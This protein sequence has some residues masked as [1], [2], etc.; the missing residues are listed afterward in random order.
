MIEHLARYLHYLCFAIRLHEIRD[1]QISLPNHYQ[2]IT[3]A[4]FLLAVPGRLIY[5]HF[6]VLSHPLS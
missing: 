2:T 3:K 6:P 1:L 5:R 4:R